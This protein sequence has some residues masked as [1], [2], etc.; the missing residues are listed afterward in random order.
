MKNNILVEH[1]GL[2]LRDEVVAAHGLHV[3]QAAKLLHVSRPALSKVINGK[4]KI[5][6]EMAFR[7]SKVF[8]GSADIWAKLQ[9]SYDLEKAKQRT[10]ATNLEPFRKN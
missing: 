9:M 7:I 3:T 8:G 6:L 10:K 4:A 5:S 2:I 1:P